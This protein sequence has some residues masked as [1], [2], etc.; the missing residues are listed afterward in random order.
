[1]QTSPYQDITL[2]LAPMLDALSHP[3]R[4]QIVLHL[5]KYKNC[6]A[7]SIST[8][9]P[10]CK[11]TVSQHMSKLK[12][13][14]LITC[15]PDGVYQNYQLND[16]I[17]ALVKNA[18]LTKVQT[19]SVKPGNAAYKVTFIELGSVRCIPCQHMQIVMKSIEEKYGDQVNVDFYDV[20]TPEGR[21]YGQQYGI[22]AIP[23]QVFLD[24][25]GKEFFRHEGYFPEEE[26]V[27]VLQTKGVK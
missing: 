6:P 24:E 4:L 8:R 26:L 15:T 3:A 11:S 25:K 14:G 1:M 19:D 12:K 23:T 13:A 10:L 21:P 7:G 2:K 27:K 16:K 22:Q 18:V 20:W 9:L 17:F 5:A